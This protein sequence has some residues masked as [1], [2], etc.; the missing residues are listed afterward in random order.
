MWHQHNRIKLTLE[1]LFDDIQ[2]RGDCVASSGVAFWSQDS[3]KSAASSVGSRAIRGLRWGLQWYH[4]H[5]VKIG[6]VCKNAWDEYV[7]DTHSGICHARLDR[8][9]IEEELGGGAVLQH[10]HHLLQHRQVHRLDHLHRRLHLLHFVQDLI[11]F[12]TGTLFVDVS[13]VGSNFLINI[14]DVAE[15]N[16]WE[17]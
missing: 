1:T 8:L 2:V 14:C 17:W 6:P 5:Y 7:F 11:T 16:E 15:K 4:H 13:P 12:G 3:W 9:Q 10:L